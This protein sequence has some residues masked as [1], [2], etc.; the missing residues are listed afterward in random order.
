M[1]LNP[2][3]IRAVMIEIEKSQKY[4]LDERGEVTKDYLSLESINE[5]LPDYS[6]EDIY[7][8][9]FNLEQAGYVNLSTQWASNVVYACA[10]NYMTFSG[11]EFLNGIRDSKKW[12]TIKKGLSVV[13]DYSLA[14][15]SAVSEGVANAAIG[16]FVDSLGL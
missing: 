4:Y 16:K 2:D 7:Y 10:V 15:I 1:K 5:A 3:C 6:K 9:L 12:S 13:G 14:V 8:S 11:H